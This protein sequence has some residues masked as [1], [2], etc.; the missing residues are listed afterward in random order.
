MNSVKSVEEKWI[1]RENVNWKEE[2]TKEVKVDKK[3]EIKR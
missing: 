2:E 3:N 1:R